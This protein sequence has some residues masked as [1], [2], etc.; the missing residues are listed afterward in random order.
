MLPRDVSKVAAYFF[1]GS[2]EMVGGAEY[3]LLILFSLGEYVGIMSAELDRLL[4]LVPESMPL[5]QSLL[6]KRIET[7]ISNHVSLFAGARNPDAALAGLALQLG[8]WNAAHTIAQDV[9]NQEG[10]YWHGIIHRMEPDYWNSN[11]WLRR[12]GSHPIHAELRE[13]AVSI[14]QTMPV[15]GWTVPTSWSFEVFNEWVED[16]LATRNAMKSNAATAIH[17]REIQFLFAFCARTGHS[18]Y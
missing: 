2:T 13:A 15:E 14:L 17:T 7:D 1:D 18:H 9:S 4:T 3:C 16:A 8:D 11:Y 12:V 5:T 10:S 6:K